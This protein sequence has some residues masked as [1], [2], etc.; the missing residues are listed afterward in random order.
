MKKKMDA[1]ILEFEE[2]NSTVDKYIDDLESDDEKELAPQQRNRTIDHQKSIPTTKANKVQN[3]G[4]QTPT[5]NPK[6]VTFF[7]ELN[8]IYATS[9]TSSFGSL[10][11]A[12]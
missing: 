7:K 11:Y 2:I 5:L 8:G 6:R 12:K 1:M 9:A 4:I 10:K 3:D